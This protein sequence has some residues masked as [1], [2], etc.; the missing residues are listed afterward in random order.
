MEK[1]DIFENMEIT[2]WLNE[3]TVIISKENTSLEKMSLLELAN[4]YPR[5]LYTYDIDT[6]EFQL[7]KEYKGGNLGGGSLSPDKK[8]LFYYEFTVGDPAFYIMNMNTLDSFTI[9]GA[10]SAKWADNDKIIGAS[11]YGGAYLASTTGEMILVEDLL[12]EALVIVDK[13]DDYIY[14]NTN[15]DESL[16]RL[17]LA[18][19]ERISLNIYNLH[20]LYPSPDGEQILALQSD[21]GAKMTL[22]LYDMAGANRSIIAEGAE[23]EGVSWSLDK[24]MIAYNVKADVKSGGESGFYVHDLLTDESTQIASD[25]QVSTSKWS[26]S[27]E[28]LVFTEYDGKEYKASIVYLKEQ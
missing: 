3:N 21:G 22:A 17:N 4:S 14:Y 2:D 10:M 19:N 27:G 9:G 13:I 7:L 1:M 6:K 15:S 23:I 8:N 26:G 18:T 25:T 24:R 11:Y 28:K 12:E 20:G 5:S 16:W